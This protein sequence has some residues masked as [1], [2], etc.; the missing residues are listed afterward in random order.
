MVSQVIKETFRNNYADDYRD[1]D[2]YYKILFNSGRALQQRELNQLQTIINKDIEEFGNNEFHAGS[3]VSGGAAAPETSV[4]FIKLTGLGDLSASDIINTPWLQ[5]G[6]EGLELKVEYAVEATD[7][8]PATIY[9]TYTSSNS[10]SSTEQIVATAGRTLTYNGS[11]ASLVGKT[12]TIQST[13][14][15]SNPAT[16]LGTLYTL[17]AGRFFVNGHFVY[18]D[19]Q[20]IVISRYTR[21]PDAVIGWKVVESIVKVEDDENLYDNSGANL[22]I[23][24]PG[25]DRYKITLILTTQALV[26][27]DEYFIPLA[28]MVAGQVYSDRNSSEGNF[29]DKANDDHFAIRHFKTH[30]S[31]KVEGGRIDIRTAADNSAMW[32]VDIQPF[33]AFLEGRFIRTTGNIPLRTAKPRTTLLQENEATTVAF[34]NYIITD[35]LNGI[36]DFESFEEINLYAATGG[37]GTVLG[38]A[39]VR[40]IDKF[41]TDYRIYLFE[42]DAGSNNFS[43]VRS[44]G[45]GTTDYADIKLQGGIAKLY[46]QVENNLLMP[47]PRTR[48]S[49]VSD[50]VITVQRVDEVTDGDN[51]GT[52]SFNT[53]SGYVVDDTSSWIVVRTDTG[54]VVTGFNTS[55]SSG[56]TVVISG[57]PT[58]TL[59]FRVVTYQQSTGSV[60]RSKT[61]TLVS[62][63]TKTAS[64]SS[65]SL[66]LDHVD[67]YAL[68]SVTVGGVD[69]TD[70]FIFDN[71]Q[72]D[73]F[74]D[75]GNITLKGGS[76]IS[77][78]ASVTVDYDYFSHS[79][80]GNFFSVSSYGGQITY[81]NIPSHQ[82]KN[83]ERVSLRDVLDFRPSRTPGASTFGEIFRLP[84]NG[85]NVT[86]DVNYYLGTKAKVFITKDMRGNIIQGV[87]ALNPVQIATGAETMAIAEIDFAP[88]GL[89]EKDF[90]IRYVGNKRYTMRDIG[91]LER[92]LEDLE[93]LTSLTMLE[94][95]T[96]NKAILD[97]DGFDRLKSGITA[98]N[99][100]DHYQSDKWL[101]NIPGAA[102]KA[103]PEYKASIDFVRG[104]LTP[105][106]LENSVEL[107]FDS[108]DASNS[109]VVLRGDNVMLSY[110]E[111]EYK[112]QKSFS[113][114][115]EVA[116][117]ALPKF[118]GRMTISPASDNWIDIEK[119]PKKVIIGDPRVSQD[120]NDTT[121]WAGTS[122][123]GISTQDLAQAQLGEVVYQG[124]SNTSSYTTDQFGRVTDHEYNVRYDVTVT[125]TPKFKLTGATTEIETVGTDL[126]RA[127]INIPVARS[128]FVSFKVTGLK[129]DTRHY[130]FLQNRDV[131]DWIYSAPGDGEFVRMSNLGRNS[132]Y[133][134]VGNTFKDLTEFP[135][136][137]VYPGKTSAHY[138]N[139][140]GEISGYLLIPSTDSMQFSTGTLE[141]EVADVDDAMVI[142]ESA[143]SKAFSEYV[144]SGTL[145]Q[146]QDEEL[147]TRVYLVDLDIE[148]VE[149]GKRRVY[150]Q[151]Q[152]FGDGDTGGTDGES[153][154]GVC[155]SVDD[156]NG[157]G[158]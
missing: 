1:S 44:I 137:G 88:Y 156:T 130:F 54:A 143:F 77:S 151:Y 74:Y 65:G 118:V 97:S 46:D 91:N 25:A 144:S 43:Q 13:D 89:D 133:L 48:P 146:I 100:M 33:L 152:D 26:D 117:Q 8:D 31:F 87:P 127:N 58:G 149:T 47:L 22:N 95:N 30:G 67:I 96:R 64:L 90:K 112:F 66:D 78:T 59:T 28:N 5:S 6:S 104:E 62:G 53:A 108:A 101:E 136:T 60:G 84:Q 113:R 24:A 141:F 132:P 85:D 52:I 40:S 81:E 138:T 72:R 14:T 142:R 9:V 18:S 2:N 86:A 56:N 135:S 124:A 115:I 41:G 129:P 27:S 10:Q 21:T 119:L 20:T 73:N 12:L 121:N 102:E 105:R 123:T 139:S 61:K 98:D 83:G 4:P 63:A 71:G 140:A 106:T 68:N 36:F 7:T 116:P 76:S 93:E 155:G 80:T 51:D 150:P 154:E 3:A 131:N 120:P 153:S 103:N 57:L 42:V 107:V 38:T 19:T 157:D 128:R 110:T 148:T 158:W 82:Q 29:G 145:R 92:R 37:T 45:N 55:S 79:G 34:G 126:I 70:E 50:V 11:A 17:A 109:N 49:T 111:V 94:L 122:W 15:S 35:N 23:S 16:G 99:F 147:S 75:V 114:A 69:V 125:N 39:K 134:D 32:E